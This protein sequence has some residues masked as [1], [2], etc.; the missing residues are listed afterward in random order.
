MV[1]LL[2]SAAMI[3]IIVAV[4]IGVTHQRKRVFEEAFRALGAT[5]VDD[6]RGDTWKLRGVPLH[7]AIDYPVRVGFTA[8]RTPRARTLC[9]AVLAPGRPPFEMDLRPQTAV[10]ERH[11]ARGRAIDLVLGDKAFDESFVV[12]AAPSDMTRALLDEHARTGLLALFPCQMTV[13]GDALVFA[14][15]GVLEDVEEVKRVVELCAHVG[16]RLGALP[17]EFLEQRIAAAREGELA[18]YRGPSPEAMRTLER[19]P[20]E[21]SE[22]EALHVARKRRTQARITQAV[23][24]VFAATVLGFLLARH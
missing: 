21:S 3:A 22:I 19:A 9:R 24:V 1:G 14:K 13:V 10:E 6:L 11:I 8:R 2:F 5:P 17:A 20:G 18:G 4:H 23:L 7:Y 12:E 15:A 16:A